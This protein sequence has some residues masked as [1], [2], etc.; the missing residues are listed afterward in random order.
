MKINPIRQRAYKLF[1]LRKDK[2][3]SWAYASRN[4]S[5]L[6]VNYNDGGMIRPH[7][8]KLFVFSSMEHAV[9]FGRVSKMDSSEWDIWEVDA[10]GVSVPKVISYADEHAILSFWNNSMDIVTK[11]APTGTLLCASLRMLKSIKAELLSG[12]TLDLLS[13]YN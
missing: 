11:E 10:F 3:E 6:Y 2:L 5:Q 8:G 4:H 13:E 1:A 9:V 7:L 12:N